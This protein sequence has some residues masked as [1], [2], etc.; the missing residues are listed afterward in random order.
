[1]A[2]CQERLDLFEGLALGLGHTRVDEEHRYGREQ[3]VQEEEVRLSLAWLQLVESAL[4]WRERES[5]QQI[6]TKID[7]DGGGKRARA[8]VEWEYFRDDQPRD[9]AETHLVAAHVQHEC[10]DDDGRP[11]LG[12]RELVAVRVR[13]EEAHAQHGQRREHHR[14][15][16]EEQ[17][18]AA[19]AVDEAD[20]EERRQE[21]RGADDDG[22]AR[23]EASKAR[24]LEDGRLIVQDG[25]LA[26]ELL[27]R[28][29]TEAGDKGSACFEEVFPACAAV[30]F[31]R[32]LDLDDFRL[33]V[34]RSRAASEPG[35]R[36]DSGGAVH[37]TRGQ[38]A[39][40]L[41]EQPARRRRHR[42]HAAND[43]D[44]HEY[45]HAPHDAPLDGRVDGNVAERRHGEAHQ[46]AEDDEAFLGRNEAA[47]HI[48]GCHLRDVD[49]RRVHRERVAKAVDDSTSEC[50][51]ECKRFRRHDRDE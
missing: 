14:D 49:W 18:S 33:D 34:V 36:G 9:R 23:R 24:G 28:N 47:A 11:P 43:G 5:H 39:D 1:M 42:E 44:A 38:V 10:E 4:Q 30:V 31:K 15:A 45:R 3:S 50:K 7:G 32:A 21:L 25:R 37:A 22:G 19:E 8:A 46:Y 27:Q 12:K 13:E 17:W 16:G 35:E 6:E 48:R 29:E 40:R 26:G 2:R 41:Q 51:S 20:G